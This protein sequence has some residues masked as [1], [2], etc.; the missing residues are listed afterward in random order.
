MIRVLDRALVA[1]GRAPT[2][3][4]LTIVMLVAIVATWAGSL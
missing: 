3:V 4:M 1:I 2:P